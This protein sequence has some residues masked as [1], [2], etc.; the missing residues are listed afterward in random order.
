MS[1]TIAPAKLGMVVAR[2]RDGRLFK[3]ITKDFYPERPEF[4]IHME[5]DENH[6]AVKVA[7]SELKA[8]FFVRSYG[9]D[10][11][12]ETHD[13]LAAAHGQGRKVVVH[14]KDGETLRGFTMGYNPTKR[15]FFVIP[16]D[17]ES[18]NLRVYVVADA[19]DRVEWWHP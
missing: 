18:N 19:V 2:F 3:G 12:H 1:S 8:V 6:P 7:V 10:P 14:F 4:H 9:G 13:D 17:G 5:G 16:S 11:A 15:G